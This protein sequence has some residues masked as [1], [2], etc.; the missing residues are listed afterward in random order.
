MIASYASKA[1]LA[2]P[3][4]PWTTTPLTFEE[5]HLDLELKQRTEEYKARK[6]AEK[7]AKK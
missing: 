4:D 6:R 3:A 2:R 7:H 1:L 5:Y